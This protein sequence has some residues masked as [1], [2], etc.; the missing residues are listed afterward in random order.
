MNMKQKKSI[1]DAVTYFILGIGIVIILIPI[2]FTVVTSLKT[3]ENFSRDFFGIPEQLY[4]ANFAEVIK[5]QNFFR[6][7]GNSLITTVLAVGLILI[8]APAV[9][10]AIARNFNKLYYKILYFLIIGG[11]FVPFQIIL[12]PEVKMASALGLMTNIGVVPIYVALGF[13]SYVFLC[14]GYMKSIPRELD[15]SAYIDGA[16]PFRTFLNIIYPLSSTIIATVA[17]MAVLW[18]WND[19]FLPLLMLNSGNEHWTLTMY[20]Y[21]FRDQ[22]KV[23]YTVSAAAFIITSISFLEYP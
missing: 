2:Y 7:F 3:P 18:I 1:M 22:F 8:L 17:I 21:N 20:A 9:S 10:Y 11:M 15:E 4:F 6:Y 12:V 5:N 14:V 16:G 23:D 13:S 19:F